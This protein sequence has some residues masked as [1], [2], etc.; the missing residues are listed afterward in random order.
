MKHIKKVSRDERPAPAFVWDWPGIAKNAGKPAYVNF[1]FTQTDSVDP[2]DIRD[3][4]W[5]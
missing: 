1:L 4:G 3:F 5:F 2:T